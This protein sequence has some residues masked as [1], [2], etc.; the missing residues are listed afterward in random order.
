[1]T[2]SSDQPGGPADGPRPTSA[3]TERNPGDEAAPAT[4][5][6]VENV[7]RR[8]GGSG[9]VGGAASPD[10]SGTGVVTVGVGGA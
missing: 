6:T 8:C 2:T 3:E 9:K 7:C 5:G 4:P 1:M 10:C